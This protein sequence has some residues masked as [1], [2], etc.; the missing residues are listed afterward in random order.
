MNAICPHCEATLR[1]LK[2]VGMDGDVALGKSW[3]CVVYACP[4]CNKAISAQIDPIAIQA[5]TIDA[6]KKRY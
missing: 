1:S 4:S 2:I 3:K 5:D 6:I